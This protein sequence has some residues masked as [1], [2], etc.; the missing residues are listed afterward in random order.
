M[1]LF[2]RLFYFQ[3]NYFP[4]DVYAPDKHKRAPEV[5]NLKMAKLK[6]KKYDS[7]NFNILQVKTLFPTYLYWEKYWRWS[8]I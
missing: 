4:N 6:F 3:V 1:S 7:D 5:Q 2:Q 8:S